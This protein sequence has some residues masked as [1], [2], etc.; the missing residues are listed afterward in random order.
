VIVAFKEPCGPIHPAVIN[1]KVAV[2]WNKTAC[3]YVEIPAFQSNLLPP[4][5]G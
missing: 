5:S 2:F 4:F 3:S 1:M